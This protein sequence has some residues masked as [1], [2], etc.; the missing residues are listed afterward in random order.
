MNMRKVRL[1]RMDGR[2]VVSIRV[3]LYV[4]S[5][6]SESPISI[7]IEVEGEGVFL[8]ACSGDGGLRLRRNPSPAD[9]GDFGSSRFE[10]ALRAKGP[11]FSLRGQHGVQRFRVGVDE[12]ELRNEDDE[13]ILAV[14][15][16][17]YSWNHGLDET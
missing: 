12:Y 9:F 3:E 1:D 2:I 14:N 7:W 8:F 11:L 17:E 16:H 5:D 4:D 15:G 10:P 6:G 13:L